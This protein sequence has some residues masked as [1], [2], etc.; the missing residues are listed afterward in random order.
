MNDWITYFENYRCNKALLEQYKLELAHS[1]AAGRSGSS[2][3]R[4]LAA[5]ISG[6]EDALA[7]AGALLCR[8]I[9]DDAPIKEIPK[10]A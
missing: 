4:E 6:L 1:D 10:Y 8:Y 7:S 9:P 3:A 2:A 5:I